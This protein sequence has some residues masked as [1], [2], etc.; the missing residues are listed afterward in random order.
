[1]L[2][3]LLLLLLLLPG[4]LHWSDWKCWHPVGDC[5]AA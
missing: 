3:L 4:L 5:P 2:L 1:V